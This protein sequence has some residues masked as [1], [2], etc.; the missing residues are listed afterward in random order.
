MKEL[1][2]LLAIACVGICASISASAAESGYLFT[3]F[4][5]ETTPLSE[6]IY[7]GV[8]ADGR[9][10][11]ALNGGRLAGAALDV[12]STEPPPAT[13]PLIGA[14]NCLITP[15]IAWA[16]LE[17]RTRLIGTASRNVKAFLEGRPENVVS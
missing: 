11:D 13:N 16:T 8:S 3:T 17:A 12:L 4:R 6:Q 5:D 14:K 15:H 7:M 2:I 10:W 9:H 1:L